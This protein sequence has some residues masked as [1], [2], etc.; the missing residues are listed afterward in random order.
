MKEVSVQSESEAPARRRFAHW[1]PISW[2]GLRR[3]RRLMLII[4]ALIGVIWIAEATILPWIVQHEV[5]KILASLGFANTSFTVSDVSLTRAVVS[6]IAGGQ[7]DDPSIDAVV[8]RYSPFA[9]I[10]GHLNDIELSGARV[11]V[12]ADRREI[13]LGRA[14]AVQ[15]VQSSA[16][17]PSAPATSHPFT[18]IGFRA[19]N[20]VLRSNGRDYWIPFSGAIQN[21]GGAK[22]KFDIT[23]YANGATVALAGQTDSGGNADLSLSAAKL[24]LAAIC[25]AASNLIGP[26]IRVTG[27][28]DAE[29]GYHR[30]AGSSSMH[31][32]FSPRN[33]A[34][35]AAGGNHHFAV[36]H[37]EGNLQADFND[38]ENLTKIIGETSIAG[39]AFDQQTVGPTQI[40]LFTVEDA[41]ARPVV[42]LTV[43]A[44]DVNVP[45][46]RLN[47]H[48]ILTDLWTYIPDSGK[49]FVPG[50]GA[51]GTIKVGEL[52]M[53]GYT[54][55]GD[56][57]STPIAILSVAASRD[58]RGIAV[59]LDSKTSITIPALSLG[60]ATVHLP[61]VSVAGSSHFGGAA[62][63]TVQASIHLDKASAELAGN[64]LGIDAVS[65]DLPVR[66]NTKSTDAG[67]LAIGAVHVGATTLPGLTI[68]AAV[69][70]TKLQA[71]VHWPVI[72]GADLSVKAT[73]DIAQAKG[74]AQLNLPEFKLTDADAI[75]A[76]VPAAAG[77]SITGAFSGKGD[78][79]FESGHI[80]PAITFAMKDVHVE[81]K[82]YAAT[83][84]GLSA[85]I[86]SGS[87]SPLTSPGDQQLA[88]KSAKVGKLEVAN[89]TSSFRVESGRSIL[90]EKSKWDWEGG[91]LHT[92]AF[93]IDPLSPVM[94]F[95]VTGNDLNLK[96]VLAT[97]SPGQAGG[98]GR[99]Y[100]RFPVKVD[101]P[102]ISFGKGFLYSAPG[103]GTVQ[104]DQPMATRMGDLLDSSDPRFKTDNQFK[105]IKQRALLAMRDFQYDVFKADWQSTA[106]GVVGTLH[107][108]GH[109]RQATPGQSGAGQG[110]NLNINFENLDRALTR[111]LIITKG[112]ANQ[113]TAK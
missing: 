110:L 91:T 63:A 49:G 67:K 59:A 79:Q 73:M 25:S 78:I 54:L 47:I 7:Q 68:A 3:W 97:F 84:D 102:G 94:N 1:L 18:R 41:N 4:A 104:L 32:G 58:D 31:I 108:E 33:I 42:H 95:T 29:F 57:T 22:L 107:L 6:Q 106:E 50:D 61:A 85:S 5:A 53:A 35:L 100:G 48:E 62:G 99:L 17:P 2:I 16:P 101:W 88:I 14:V 11:V 81:D 51:H 8:V 12:D 34:V 111:Y 23:A 72:K 24:D 21:A 96:S 13:I 76:I 70:Q 20:L 9:V 40:S 80:L 37:F 86:T 75:A 71:D 43:G 87:F 60:A 45:G 89:G 56:Q 82:A 90:I 55:R 15:P 77:V 19:C 83:I 36:D 64:K 38:H 93:R 92:D 27:L 30:A 39:A 74:D 113:A 26:N 65:G 46:A 98:E 69:D 52:S 105:Q 103:P 44:Q 66:W 109:G 10:R 112:T 28:A